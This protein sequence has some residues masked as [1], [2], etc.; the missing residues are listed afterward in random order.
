MITGLRN[1]DFIEVSHLILY[2]YQQQSSAIL[3][4]F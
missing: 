1:K 4:K 3:F 2:Q